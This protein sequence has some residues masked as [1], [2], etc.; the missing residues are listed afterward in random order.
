MN[1]KYIND[2]FFLKYRIIVD[3][4]CEKYSYDI[5]LRHLL[6]LVI[7]IFVIKYGVA[8][9]KIIIKG[10]EEIPIIFGSTPSETMKAYFQRKLILEG[11]LYCSKKYIVINN[12][13]KVDY[14]YLLDSLLH[15]FNHAIN[16][17]NNEII[18]KNQNILLR[19]GISYIVYT[20]K[21]NDFN[22]AKTKTYVLEE[23]INTKQTEEI[24]ELICKL[25]I[26]NIKNDEIRE[27]IVSIRKELSGKSYKSEAYKLEMELSKDLINNRT[28]FSTLE[29]SRII[30]EVEYV[31]EWFDDI[32]GE[33]GSYVDL[34][35][36][37]YEI[38][39]FERKY[40]EAL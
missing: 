30:G 20:K 5:N 36:M 34:N 39:E 2:L 1:E 10:F 23:I 8:N 13:I 11:E 17:M 35:N 25:N 6:Y 4:I 32:C 15:E 12:N 24:I 9:E 26:E 28:F 16:S 27:L 37:L 21:D 7:P 29:N 38:L 14:I 19:T 18:I 33:K 31:E 40:L 22:I 3:K